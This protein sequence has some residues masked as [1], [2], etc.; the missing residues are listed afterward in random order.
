MTCWNPGMGVQAEGAADALHQKDL[1]L[2][3]DEQEGQGGW[4][5]GPGEAVK[6]R[7]PRSL[8]DRRQGQVTGSWI[9]LVRSR[10]STCVHTEEAS[11]SQDV[12]LDGCGAP[13]SCWHG[14]PRALG[15]RQLSDLEE[16]RPLGNGRLIKT[17]T[18]FLMTVEALGLQCA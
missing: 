12:S 7:D 18:P 14:Q 5:V 16:E 9:S 1:G 17:M 15:P 2:F 11:E 10:K 8:E 4:D 13:T 6:V 3:R